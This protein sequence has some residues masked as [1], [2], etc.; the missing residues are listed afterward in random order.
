MNRCTLF[1]LVFA[2][3]AAACGGGDDGPGGDGTARVVAVGTDFSTAGIVTKIAVPSLEVTTNAVDGV[4][5]TDPVIRR[6]GD[7]LYVINRFGADNVTILDREDLSLIAQ[8]STGGGSNP[9]DVAPTADSIYVTALASPGVLVL[10]AADPEA[11]V[12]SMI[13]L[14]DLDPEDGLPN[15]STLHV[16]GDRLYVVCQILDDNDAF[17]TPRGPGQVA[18]IDLADDSVIDT[19]AMQNANPFGYLA[20]SPA[21][22]GDLVIPTVPSF[23]DLTQGCVQRISTG[24]SPSVSCLVTNQELGGYA[25]SIADTGDGSLLLAV[26]ESFDPDDRGPLGFAIE[27]DPESGSVDGSPMTPNGQRPFDIAVCPSGH[28]ALA[29][30]DGGI[31]I[32]ESLGTELTTEPLDIGLPPVPHGLTCY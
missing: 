27:F 3:V 4:A 29:D 25:A 17:L 23:A 8:V 10:D 6:F 31:R 30:A 5:S 24:A 14:S 9:Q 7:Q 15:C 18:V 21:L 11:G 26:T 2:T 20:L 16:V 1:C 32:Y 28:I 19:I 22:D 13:D 12:A